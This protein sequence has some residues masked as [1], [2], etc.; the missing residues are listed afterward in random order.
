MEKLQN[1]FYIEANINNKYLESYGP[2]SKEA[3]F[4]FLIT[5]LLLSLK[6]KYT[7][8][9]YLSS[10]LYFIDDNQKKTIYLKR[11]LSRINNARS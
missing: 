1:N 8:P 5:N 7:P 11:N 6:E 4:N 10:I 9:F 3:A 2:F